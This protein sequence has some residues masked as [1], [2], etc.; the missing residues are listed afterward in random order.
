MKKIKYLVAGL[1]MMGLS[2]P[3]MAQNANY[4]DLLKPIEQTLKS[5]PNLDAKGL[6]DLTK[7]YQKE[8]KKDPK[9]LVALGNTLLMSKKYDDASAIGNMVIAKFKDCGDAYVL[10]GD[11]AAMKDDGG[12]AA[13][14]YQQSMTMDPKN[15]NGYMR[16]ANVY[17]KRSPEESE[18]ALN[19]LKQV[20]PDYPIEAE[21][22]NNFYLGG[23]YAKAYEYFAKT[24]K[25]SLD[26]YYL[27]AYAVSAYMN[28][29]KDESLDIAKFG[30]QKFAQNITFDRVALWSAVD[31]QKFDDAITYANKIV[32]T[33]SVEKSARDYIYYGLALKGNKQ[34]QQAID[35][36]NKAFDMEKNNFKPYQYIADAYAE[37]GQEDKAL[38][39]SEKYMANN[40]DATPSD[41]AKLANIYI[42]KAAK[43]DANKQ[44]NLDKAYS[45]YDQMAVK[46]PTIA[47]WVNNM[48]G[49]QA[50][51]AGQDDKSVEY[52]NKVVTML[53][54][55]ENREDDETNTLKSALA[56]L[57]YY[58]WITKQNLDAAKPIYEQLI[59]LDPNDK[60][61]RA[62]LGLDKPEDVKK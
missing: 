30:T 53:G 19:L 44:A 12:D 23:N 8:F 29:K 27:V 37:M 50:S 48:A 31:T 49:M 11:V 18:R 21:A 25:E 14:W 46:W 62:A 2:V 41:Y 39:Y 38:E 36:Y 32:T 3:G 58:Y 13:M 42:Q 40:Q 60:N 17:R 33:D 55:K 56:N 45:I 16:Y 22:G 9:A 35:Q 1:L 52:F 61:A 5:N 26:Q 51:K 6:K 20:R 24:Q 43:G 10:L 34:Y 7:E 15:P 57:G 4:N 59:K 28:N 54:N 47:A